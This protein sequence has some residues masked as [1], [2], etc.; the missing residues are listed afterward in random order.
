VP[1]H[2]RVPAFLA[3]IDG[4]AYGHAEQPI[5]AAADITLQGAFGEEWL[6][7]SLLSQV[8]RLLSRVCYLLSEARGL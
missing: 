3:S 8:C 5:V 4:S 7:C 2:D 1:L 6:V